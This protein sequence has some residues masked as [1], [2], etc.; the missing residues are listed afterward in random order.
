MH[1]MRFMCLLLL[2]DVHHQ[3]LLHHYHYFKERLLLVC[4]LL[5]Q[6]TILLCG[7]MRDELDLIQPCVWVYSVVWRVKGYFAEV[8]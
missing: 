7:I 6:S 5:L 4:S 8:K 3:S 2:G 1:R